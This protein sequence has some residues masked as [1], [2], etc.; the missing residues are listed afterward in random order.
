MIQNQKLL[1]GRN[2][3]PFMQKF[4]LYS[5]FQI[6]RVWLLASSEFYMFATNEKYTSSLF[7][8]NW[9]I[10]RNLS[11]IVVCRSADFLGQ[12]NCRENTGH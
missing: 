10:S 8:H 3:G 4:S 7:Q 1:S 6:S 11:S 12:E 2:A 9:W 5:N